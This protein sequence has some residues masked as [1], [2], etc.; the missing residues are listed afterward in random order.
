MNSLLRVEIERNVPINQG[1]KDAT[2][3]LRLHINSDNLDKL[4]ELIS[5]KNYCKMLFADTSGTQPYLMNKY[6]KNV[7]SI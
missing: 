7:S 4:L 6:I 5:F 2:A 1:M 3:N